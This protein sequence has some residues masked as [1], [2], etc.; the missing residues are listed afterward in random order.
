MGDWI[1]N[2]IWLGLMI[3]T[4]VRPGGYGPYLLLGSTC[5]DFLVTLYCGLKY[6]YLKEEDD[7]SVGSF[8]A[9][10]VAFALLGGFYVGNLSFR[11]G[12]DAYNNALYL[13][14]ASFWLTFGFRLCQYGMPHVL[15]LST[16]AREEDE[17]L[18]LRTKA[19]LEE[20]EKTEGEHADEDIPKTGA[21]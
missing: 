19:M 2:I 13:I 15:K 11:S 8:L 14:F 12:T 18:I 6:G 3:W 1:F 20:R 21:G 9:N 4:C 7:F 17:E 10:V 16:S 5:G